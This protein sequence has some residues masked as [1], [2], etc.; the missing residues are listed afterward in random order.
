MNAETIAQSR[1]TS[2]S[3]MSSEAYRQ[4]VIDVIWRYAS[5]NGT[6][7]SRQVFH[8]LK[9]VTG[10]S[11]STVKNWMH[12]GIGLPD[13]EALS[14][15]VS[16]WGIP[17]EELFPQRVP[18]AVEPPPELAAEEAPAAASSLSNEPH[19]LPAFGRPNVRA[20]NRVFSKYTANPTWCVWV[21]QPNADAAGVVD[22]GEVMLVDPQIERITGAGLYILR[23]PLASGGEDMVTRWVQPLTGQALARVSLPN[24]KIQIGMSEEFPL[25]ADGKFGNGIAV[26]GKV[27]S[28]NRAVG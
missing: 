25:F 11:Y 7:D 8:E 19:V 27:L 18:V 14:F 2:G 21:Q 17:A 3:G 16:H 10:R 24:T 4:H 13:V 5:R 22:Q 28:V 23:I 6:L 9:D 15:V 26:V 12:F 20:I 1:D